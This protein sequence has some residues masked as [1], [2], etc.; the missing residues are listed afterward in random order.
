M[1]PVI[2]CYAFLFISFLVLITSSNYLAYL[3]VYFIAYLPLD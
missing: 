2:F 1:V 3:P